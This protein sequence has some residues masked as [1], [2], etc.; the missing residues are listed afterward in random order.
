MK[1]I[2]FGYEFYPSLFA[3]SFRNSDSLDSPYG[4]TITYGFQI[5]TSQMNLVLSYMFAK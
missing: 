4:K 2:S 1:N 3:I 5:D